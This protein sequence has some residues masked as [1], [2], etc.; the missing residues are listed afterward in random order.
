MASPRAPSSVTERRAPGPT[1]VAIVPHTH[2]DREWYLPFQVFRVRLVALLDALLPL[3]ERD[4]S[5]ARFLLDGQTAVL[6]DYLAVRPEAAAPLGRLAASGR[7]QVGPWMI[8]MDEFMVSGETLVRDLQLGMARAAEL[9]GGMRVGYLPDMFGH[10]A[11]MPQLL[12]QAG[13]E[14]AVVWRGVPAAVTRT[15]FWWEAPDGSRVRAEYLYGSYSNGRDLPEDAKALVGRAHGYELELGDA[16]LP[17]G[18][19][20][21]MNGTDHQLPQ[22]WLGRVVA[23][24]NAIQDDYRFVVTSL[25]EYLPTQPTAGLA[26]WPGELRSGARA[27]VLM[28]VAS[29]RVDVHRACA[30]A[31]RA[32]E[33]RAEPLS[34]LLRPARDYPA[35][36]LEIGWRQLVLN[37]AHDSSCACSHDEVVDAVLVRYHEAR[38]VGDALVRDALHA[39]A[40]RVAAPAGA[41][42]VVNPTRSARGGL[43]EGVVPGA[44]PMHLEADDGTP[45]ATQV[46]WELGTEGFQ[47]VVTGQKVRWVLELLRGSEFAAATI[48]EVTRVELA[49]D[50]WEY[51]FRAARPG[52]PA[53]DLEPTRE[54]LLALAEAG[55][56]IRFKQQ[57]APTRGIVFAA[58][59][60]PGFGWRTYRAVG[61]DGP[62]TAVRA[63]G[64]RLENEHLTVAVDPDDGRLTIE[65]RDGVRMEG[66]NRL[67]DGGDGGD[68]Y[69][70]SPPT[71]DQVVDRPATVSVAVVE[72]GPVRAALE[73]SAAYRWPVGAVGDRRAC[74]RRQVQTVTGE[75]RTRLELRVGERFLR[76]RVTVENRAR[77]HRLR[78]HFPL[79]VTVTGSDAECAF[80]VVR[81][82]LT[83]EGG[84]HEAGLPTF[85]SRRFVDVSDGEVGL[86][87]LHDGLLEYE[88]VEDGRELALTLL[89]ATGYL[90]RVE[91]A[92]RPNPAGPL[93][94]LEGPQLQGR[95]VAEYALLPHRGDWAAADL[96][97]A[98]AEFLVPLERARVG[99]TTGVEAATGAA[100]RVDGAEVSA[101]AR[102]AALLSVR[103]FNPSPS[104]SE[105]TVEHDGAPARGYVVDLLGRPLEPFEGGISLRPWGIATLRLS[106]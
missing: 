78:A 65:T 42:L 43:V 58:D 66:L 10:V 12:A 16:R 46:T 29:N 33:L 6:D 97:A 25:P 2:W 40:G 14:H 88:V 96:Y 38:Q 92:L 71:V 17:D 22:P 26:T 34:A 39:L 105:V 27:S 82:G 30:V 83:A 32:L 95:Q 45:C 63:A 31:E 69:N 76:V 19:L 4:L 35:A 28:G 36:L 101:V 15:A 79:P 8:L 90:S 73:V 68:T 41:T 21:L 103:V 94:P 3:L 20:L 100:L 50:D 23:E 48:A 37:S 64:T 60:V 59:S 99:T 106:G 11:Q 18:A 74:E 49:P 7:L 51:T 53:I 56:T 102:E 87:V 61:G 104:R 84:P 75:V 13:F 55:A 24:A 72:R 5:Y 85:V 1:T 52:E 67:V 9:G 77:D 70:Y 57:L 44:G 93:D 86:G 91:P 80:A 47:T 62:A 98:A 81:R 89:R 54:E